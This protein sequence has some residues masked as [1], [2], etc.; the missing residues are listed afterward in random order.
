MTEP[1]APPVAPTATYRLQ[2]QPDFPF[3]AAAAVV[4]HLAALGVSHLHLSPVL[5]AVPGSTHGYDVTDHG[6]VRAE[7]GGEEGLRALA[8]TAHEHGMGLVVD[9]V[10]NHMAVP[11][12]ER[13][14]PALWEVL[15]D[16]PGSPFA[17]WFDVDWEAQ[18]DRLLLPVLGG[19]PEEVLDQLSVER[20][21]ARDRA[22]GGAVLRYHDHV[23]P[24][25]PGTEGLPLRELLDA[26]WYRLAHWRRARTE[27]NY[28]RFFTISGLIALR[29]EDPEVFD[30][31]HATLARLLDDGVLDGL[32]IDHPD[33]LADPA[34]YLRRLRGLSGRR[35]TV[36][37][38]I[39]TGDEE[40]P[41]D[42]A[43][44][45]TTGYDALDRIDGL[46]T[47]PA[48]LDRITRFYREFT[49]APADRGGDWTATARA[50]ARQLAEHDLAAEVDRLARA[51]S[52]ATGAGI[53]ELRAAIREVLVRVPRYRTYVQPGEPATEE[54]TAL[55]ETAAAGARVPHAET[56]RDLALGRLGR[57]PGQD[58]F[59]VR[60]PQVSSALRAK[61]IEDTAFYRWYPLLS[62]NEVGRDP[63]RAAV[64]PEEFHAYCARLARDWPLT[65][66]VRSTH[67]TK[68]SADVRARLT[69]LTELPDRW[70][71]RVREASESLRAYAARSGLAIPD[72]HVE[73]AAWQY[74]TVFAP[75]GA[76]AAD[77]VAATLLKSEREAALRTS[78]T[79]QD[80]AFERRLTDFAVELL[81]GPASYAVNGLAAELAEPARAAALGAH[82]VHL[83]MPG[84]PDV[85]QGDEEHQLLLVDPANRDPYRPGAGTEPGEPESAKHLLTRAALLLR[86]ERPG[87]F[88]G[89]DADYQPL[90]ATGPAAGHCVAFARG[91]GAITAV[92]RLAARLSASG[93]WH[94]TTLPLPDGNWTDLLTRRPHA[95]KVRVA[96]LFTA[97]P[98]ALLVRD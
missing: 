26:Q 1:A 87:W 9:I 37:E 70:E 2:L 22:R 46:F 76:A 39:L 41:A 58:D 77:T 73:Y 64:A 88:V 12:P 85:Y 91:G 23:F 56:V 51:A 13:L 74:A 79:E 36:V 66:T 44:D 62:V 10:P 8:R 7:L 95:G 82:L 98:V 52:R 34:G 33:G 81:R 97:G 68:R 16:G 4:P 17:R 84:V 45:G 42:W 60:F 78:W 47:D 67:D 61:S 15:R 86:R 40:L 35:W 49:G 18:G 89:P 59:L 72:R 24:L 80:A 75:R 28:R 20:G 96:D 5:E 27:L 71:T 19:E 6:A 54:Q 11:A 93:G 94:D 69:A 3:A 31:T 29:V 30:A 21:G 92:T 32:R 43:C 25:R 90:Y 14:A 57:G 38:K 50:A 63:E 65:G 53:T 48:G 55:L 83:T